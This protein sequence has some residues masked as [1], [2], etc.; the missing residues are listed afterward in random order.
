M[1]DLKG[2]DIVSHEAF[3]V[4]KKD[5]IKI[6][7]NHPSSEELSYTFGL[8]MS[9]SDYLYSGGN[10]TTIM[11]AVS[12]DKKSEAV[13]LLLENSGS[14]KEFIFLMVLAWEVKNIVNK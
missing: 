11:D 1:I 13:K 3:N 9:T 10:Y 4:L 8:P 12:Q 6:L 14:M 5:L 7:D 2:E